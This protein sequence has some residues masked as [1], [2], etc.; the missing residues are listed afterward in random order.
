M[1]KIVSLAKD[2]GEKPLENKREELFCVLYATNEEF[3]GNGVQSYMRAFNIDHAEQNAYARARKQASRML[4]KR[5]IL[6]RINHFLVLLDL[7]PA[8][9]D[10]QLAFV[11]TQN[12]NLAAKMDGIKVALKLQG[13]L[14]NANQTL[15]INNMSDT[16]LDAEI[17]RLQ[18]EIKEGEEAM[19]S[20]ESSA[21]PIVPAM[22]DCV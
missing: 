8:H 13:R 17:A 5:H 14:E 20:K 2:V 15:I 7:N 9:V 22:S 11:V 6:E 16:Q 4:Q 21:L 19:A 12:A 1:N 18:R 10:K 3:F